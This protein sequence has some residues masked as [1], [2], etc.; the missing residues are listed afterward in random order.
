MFELQE[1]DRSQILEV[2]KEVGVAGPRE[3]QAL[4]VRATQ[5]A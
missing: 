1:L 5:Q 4:A 2:V 3:L